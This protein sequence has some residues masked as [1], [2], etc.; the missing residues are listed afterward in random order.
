MITGDMLAVGREKRGLEL[1]WSAEGKERQRL[2]SQ[3]RT[4]VFGE[5]E[6]W[7]KRWRGKIYI[8]FGI[9]KQR[10]AIG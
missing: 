10:C 4:N 9:V 5:G 3:K 8:I 2:W 7:E 6:V 1:D